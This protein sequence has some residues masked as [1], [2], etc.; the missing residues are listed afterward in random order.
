MLQKV[1]A[2]RP[3]TFFLPTCNLHVT[4]M[5]IQVQLM[6]IHS[7]RLAIHKF[8]VIYATRESM[9]HQD[10]QRQEQRRLGDYFSMKFEV[11]YIL[12]KTVF[13]ILSV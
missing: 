3:Q 9:A 7:A 4:V 10:I 6:L 13:T 8:D 11:L 5:Q 12:L 2:C 1:C